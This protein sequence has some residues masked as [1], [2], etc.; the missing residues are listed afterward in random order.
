[1][2]IYEQLCRIGSQLLLRF[3]HLNNIMYCM[4]IAYCPVSLGV[5][6]M[7]VSLGAVRTSPRAAIAR[8]MCLFTLLSFLPA[9]L[10]SVTYDHAGITSIAVRRALAVARFMI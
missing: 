8:F 10:L 2:P 1:M 5:F 6:P 3:K 9:T 7:F 4:G